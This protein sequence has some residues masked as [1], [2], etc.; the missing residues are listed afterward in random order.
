MILWSAEKIRIINS[1][2]Q[3]VPGQKYVSE[4]GITYIGNSDNGLSVFYE[5]ENISFKSND[6]VPE[7]TVQDAVNYVGDQLKNNIKNTI[8]DFGADLYQTQKT[9]FIEDSDI[10]EGDLILAQLSYTPISTRSLDDLMLETLEFKCGA[11]S[12]GVNMLVSSLC[13]SVS[14]QFS[15][16]YYKGY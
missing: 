4:N 14:G 7:N 13:G 10:S 1:R 15:V 11:L 12:G 9:F 8:I 3:A 5:A 2:R 6:S 16:N